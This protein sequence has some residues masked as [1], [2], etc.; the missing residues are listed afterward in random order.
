MSRF[1]ELHQ[2]DSKG[3]TPV[4]VNMDWIEYVAPVDDGVLLYLGTVNVDGQQGRL[5]SR[6][7]ILHVSENYYT[8]KELLQCQ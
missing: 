6:P 1:V 2:P 7:H 5:S 8:V 3:P 4:M